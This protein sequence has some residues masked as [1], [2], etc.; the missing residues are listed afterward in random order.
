M[1]K[2]EPLMNTN[3]KSVI[4]DTQIEVHT[5]I[6][7]HNTVKDSN[8]ELSF[9]IWSRTSKISHKIKNTY[10]DRWKMLYWGNLWRMGVPHCFVSGRKW[11]IKSLLWIGQ[12]MKIQSGFPLPQGPSWD[13]RMCTVQLSTIQN[14]CLSRHWAQK[15]DWRL[16][17]GVFLPST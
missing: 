10:F 1:I 15:G 12:T 11:N 13:A 2:L 6:V 8:A 4:C 7:N 3:N 17:T 14:T 16:E 5:Q 9:L